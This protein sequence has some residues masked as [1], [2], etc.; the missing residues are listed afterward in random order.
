MWVISTP[1]QW[2]GIFG[3]RFVKYISKEK[4]YLSYFLHPLLHSNVLQRDI[5]RIWFTLSLT[6]AGM[7]PMDNTL[8]VSLNTVLEFGW[9][10]IQRYIT[11]GGVLSQMQ[12]LCLAQPPWFC[13]KRFK[14]QKVPRFWWTRPRYTKHF[15]QQSFL[16]LG[17]VFIFLW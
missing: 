9:L 4:D 15:Y 13:S 1:K 3:R 14:S 11:R 17:T 7:K 6:I 5:W 12:L 2:N 8:T 16:S 10:R